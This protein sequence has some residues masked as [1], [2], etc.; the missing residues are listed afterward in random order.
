M[1]QV[2]GELKSAAEAWGRL[3]YGALRVALIIP[4]MVIPPIPAFLGTTN[5]GKMWEK[6]ISR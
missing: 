1:E 4:N 2:T 5:N 3:S 6:I